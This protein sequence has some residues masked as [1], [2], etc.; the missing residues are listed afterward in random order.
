MGAAIATWGLPEVMIR[1][2]A[3]KG[4][5]QEE[6]DGSFSAWATIHSE[7]SF[8]VL[9]PVTTGYSEFPPDA[10]TSCS[11]LLVHAVQIGAM[12]REKSSQSGVIRCTL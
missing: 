12:K 4:T 10:R 1:P 6:S 5:S 3:A 11:L 7:W 9:L 8:L 2:S